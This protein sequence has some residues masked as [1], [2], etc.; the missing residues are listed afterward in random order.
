MKEEMAGTTDLNELASQ[1]GLS[2]ETAENVSF[3]SPALPNIGLEPNV[4][5][6]AMSLEKGQLSVP[7]QGNSGVFVIAIE[8]KSI[9]PQANIAQSRANAIQ[10]MNSV[11]ESGAVFNAL[12]EKADLTYNRAKFY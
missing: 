10:G 3:S 1:E 9:P 5:G 11:I 7:I 12:K 4:V 8:N 6:K 2:I